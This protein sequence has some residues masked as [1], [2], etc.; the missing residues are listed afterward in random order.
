M[1]IVTVRSTTSDG[2]V[3]VWER[4]PEHPNGEVFVSGDQ[5]ERRVALTS[6]VLAELSKGRLEI[7]FASSRPVPVIE[8]ET[9]DVPFSEPKEPPKKQGRPKHFG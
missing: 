4:N 2:R 3:I 6:A 5:K 7:V 1:E 8:V 9:E